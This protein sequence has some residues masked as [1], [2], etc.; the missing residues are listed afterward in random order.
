MNTVIPQFMSLIHSSKTD[1]KAK[2]KINFQ[3]EALGTMI[4]LLEEGAHISENWLVNRKTGINL[5]ILYKRENS[6]T[7]GLLYL[8]V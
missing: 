3:E 5:C 6:Y 7:E 8:C 2:T 4:S 1:H